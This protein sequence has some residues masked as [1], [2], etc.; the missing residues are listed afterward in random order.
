MSAP[1]LSAEEA[2]VVARFEAAP[3]LPESFRHRASCYWPDQ[4]C[5][6]PPTVVKI[7]PA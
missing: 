6:C 5:I 1:E 2:A 7:L 3:D 4:S